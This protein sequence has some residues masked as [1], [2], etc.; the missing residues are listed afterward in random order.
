MNIQIDFPQVFQYMLNDLSG[1]FFKSFLQVRQTCTLSCGETAA[2][3]AR[4][5]YTVDRTWI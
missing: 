4:L 1:L 3:T 5:L 2:A